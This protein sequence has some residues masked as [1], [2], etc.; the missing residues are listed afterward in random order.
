MVMLKLVSIEV[1]NN[2]VCGIVVLIISLDSVFMS[3]IHCYN[4]ELLEFFSGDNG[5]S[6]SPC[7]CHKDKACVDCRI[8]T[9]WLDIILIDYFCNSFN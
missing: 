2:H 5:L 4:T 7:L 1:S 8:Y 9:V 6:L 3:Q